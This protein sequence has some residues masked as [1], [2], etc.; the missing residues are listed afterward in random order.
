MT[1]V[2]LA[3]RSASRGLRSTKTLNQGGS[4]VHELSVT[5]PDAVIL[6]GVMGEILKD[7]C[8]PKHLRG[9]SHAEST[10]LM[11]SHFEIT[12]EQLKGFIRDRSKHDG[13]FKVGPALRS[14]SRKK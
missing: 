8:L 10:E 14:I 12:E 2:A 3:E 6:L 9:L 11:L 13:V 7:H 5:I 1:S 4:K